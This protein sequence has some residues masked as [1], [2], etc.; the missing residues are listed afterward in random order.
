MY[1]SMCTCES[2]DDVGMFLEIVDV[3][4]GL[5]GR[6]GDGGVC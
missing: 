4:S 6:E 3:G 2:K 5:G 1:I